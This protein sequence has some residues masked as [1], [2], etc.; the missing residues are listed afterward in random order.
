ML[1]SSALVVEEGY[2]P[3]GGID[4]VHCHERQRLRLN[5]FECLFTLNWGPE[6]LYCRS[7]RLTDT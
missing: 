5:E 7:E 3:A 4:G 2:D 6:H 1:R